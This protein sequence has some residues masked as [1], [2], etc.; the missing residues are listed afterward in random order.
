M[1]KPTSQHDLDAASL[2]ARVPA[3][4]LTYC[5]TATL[6]RL[7]S[8]ARDGQPFAKFFFV[9]VASLVAGRALQNQRLLPHAMLKTDAA[10]QSRWRLEA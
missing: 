10:K 2:H 1:A 4:T 5:T 9:D 7:V 3:H 8:A 6:L